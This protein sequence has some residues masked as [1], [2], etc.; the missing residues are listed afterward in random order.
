M[1][2]STVIVR[3]EDITSSGWGVGRIAA[4]QPVVFV[5]DT[6]PGELV[7]AGII[8]KKSNYSRGRILELIEPSASRIEPPCP[9]YSICPGCSLQHMSYEAQCTAKHARIERMLAKSI[10]RKLETRLIRSPEAFGYRTH[11]S[12]SCEIRG[13]ALSVGFIDPEN[14]RVVDIPA[15][16]LIPEW[17]NLEYSRLRATLGAAID[18][19]PEQFRLRLFFEEASHEMMVAAPRGPLKS[20]RR[21]PENLGPVLEAFPRPKVIERLTLGVKLLLHPAS[22]VQA[23][24]YLTE[25]LYSEGLKAANAEG[26]D[27]V[28][29]LYAGSGFFTLALGPKVK[30]IVAVEA[31][32]RAADNLV[33]N[34]SVVLGGKKHKRMREPDIQVAQGK[35]EDLAK[36]IMEGFKPTIVIANPPRSGLHRKVVEA[37]CGSESVRRVAIVSCDES[38]LGRDISLMMRSGFEP[39]EAVILDCYPQTA[40][41]EIVTAINK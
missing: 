6:I 7:R 39:G 20:Y 12:V 41:V 19:L 8:E 18:K 22:F 34:A 38:T 9:F 2:E 33:R 40:H 28:V 16:L 3:I 4:D 23:N 21:V 17:A 24:R 14:R 29:D 1:D 13:G 36:E 31:D 30:R 5:P 15:C 35:A 27:A 11:L 26:K 37:I 32:K 10:G 25:E